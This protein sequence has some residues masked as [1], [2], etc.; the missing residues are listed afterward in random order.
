[1]KPILYNAN[2]KSQ[3]RSQKSNKLSVVYGSVEILGIW[4]LSLACISLHLW[5]EALP[6]NTTLLSHRPQETLVWNDTGN[7][8]KTFLQYRMTADIFFHVCIQLQRSWI[9]SQSQ[10]RLTSGESILPKLAATSFLEHV[11]QLLKYSLGLLERKWVVLTI[12]SVGTLWYCYTEPSRVSNTKP[13]DDQ[14]GCH[15]TPIL[16]QLSEPNDL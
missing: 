8:Q 11:Q 5:I 2:R 9:M 14:T 16:T 15:Q 10:Q 4:L 13:S 6:L 12:I 7:Y 1:M 3:S